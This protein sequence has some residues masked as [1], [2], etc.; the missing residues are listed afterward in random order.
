MA[1]TAPCLYPSVPW[2]LIKT[3]DTDAVPSGSTVSTAQPFAPSF[4]A[5]PP[6]SP[7]H[8]LPALILL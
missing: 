5:A 7:P 3:D 2:R 6:P 8:L 4:I 1:L